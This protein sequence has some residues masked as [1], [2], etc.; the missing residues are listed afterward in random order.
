MND[1]KNPSPRI[2]TA[3]DLGSK[4]ITVL[5]GEVEDHGIRVRGFA[6][7]ES[8][9]IKRGSVSSL[10]RTL[11]A[12]GKA[13]AEVE[14]QTGEKIASAV[15]NIS[16]Q[17]SRC[18]EKTFTVKR[19]RKDELI[20]RGEI[21]KLCEKARRIDL[22]ADEQVIY[23]IPVSFDVDDYMGKDMDELDGMIGRVI[24]ATFK[25][26][27]SKTSFLD[28]IDRLFELAHITLEGK[29]IAPVASSLAVL[30]PDER[31]LGCV[32]LDIGAG[33]TDIL[34]M[35]DN[36][37][38]SLGVIPFAGNSV[39]EDIRT[40]TSTSTLNCERMK[41]KYGC[42]LES[43]IQ[44]DKTIL[45]R[46]TAGR[47][48]KNITFKALAHVIEA[49]MTEI[50]EA[51]AW[52]IKEA[53]Y[54]Y[55]LPAGVVITG[56]GAY[57]ERVNE[58]AQAVL[59]MPARLAAPCNRLRF[60][61]IDDVFSANSSTGVGLA[62]CRLDKLSEVPANQVQDDIWIEDAKPR[63]GDEDEMLFDRSDI[64]PA[65]RREDQAKSPSRTQVKAKRKQ[66][67]SSLK[68]LFGEF[69]SND[70]EA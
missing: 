16:G 33:T 26:Y 32:L 3:I 58:L 46:G 60:T 57:L 19:R 53:G 50:F 7:V 62:L 31:E 35:K 65:Q 20:T 56:G 41:V 15:V 36:H 38:R 59:G 25:L 6:R 9:G 55:Q 42:C 29:F 44:E 49:R 54:E 48:D 69:F 67:R 22:K 2:I 1:V 8:D 5:T 63:T 27:V 13:V 70:D 17:I 4:N 40:R 52:K 12:L 21:E 37:I 18:E 28:A 14:A 68:T 11:E 10:Q 43:A 30:S 51:V 66:E 24:T 64:Q 61:P 39:T 47:E 34:I 45:I 23:A